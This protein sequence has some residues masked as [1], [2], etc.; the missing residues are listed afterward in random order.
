MHEVVPPHLVLQR[1]RHLV[2]ESSK[3]LVLLER[4]FH[5]LVVEYLAKSGIFKQIDQYKSAL[6]QFNIIPV[7]LDFLPD[8]VDHFVVAVFARVQP[9]LILPVLIAIIYVDDL[10]RD[11]QLFRVLLR[12]ITQHY[13]RLIL[14]VLLTVTAVE[15]D[16]KGFDGVLEI[17]ADQ[18]IFF[19]QLFA[20][21]PH[22]Q[23]E[24]FFQLHMPF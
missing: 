21:L 14:F 11:R 17:V 12:L 2:S 24:W 13:H 5:L 7:Q 6:A 16:L 19:Q 4:K 8:L 20:H 9:D 10:E 23:I 22:Q 15:A 3:D 18:S 1:P